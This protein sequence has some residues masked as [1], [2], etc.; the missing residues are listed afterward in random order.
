MEYTFTTR[1][2][3]D[4]G[5]LALLDRTIDREAAKTTTHN[6]S[7]CGL[8]T[9]T[10]IRHRTLLIVG[11][12][13]SPPLGTTGS[14]DAAFRELIRRVLR[15]LTG[16]ASGPIASS[17]YILEPNRVISLNLPKAVERIRNP[18]LPPPPVR[19]HKKRQAAQTFVE[20]NAPWHLDR[21][22]GPT[23]QLDGLYRFQS[24]ADGVTIYILDTG[25]QI[26]HPEFGG[27][28]SRLANTIDGTID[29]C[30]G[31]G[32]H[33]SSLAVGL[34]FGVAKSAIVKIVKVLNC[35]GVGDIASLVGGVMAVSDD[36]SANPAKPF[37]LSM[38]LVG[39]ESA[40]MTSAIEELRATYHVIVV[41]AA[42]NSN[43]DACG[44]NPVGIAGVFG[45]GSTGSTDARSYFSNF[46]PC[47]EAYAPGEGVLGAWLNG[48]YAYLSGTSMATPIVAG[49]F[50]QL[51]EQIGRTYPVAGAGNIS[52]S[53]IPIEQLAINALL[54]QTWHPASLG[55]GALVYG[56]FDATEAN[57]YGVL[58]PG[59]PSQPLTSEPPPKGPPPFSAPQLSQPN[60]HHANRANFL[61][62]PLGVMMLTLVIIMSLG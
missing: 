41:A 7:D 22:D 10:T 37:I 17:D 58:S 32:T 9:S 40:S 33:V 60:I 20:A 46:G 48:G 36:A 38:S 3:V 31:H 61:S 13:V 24:W 14:R 25:C 21:L 12:T 27:R 55:G 53:A 49:V 44:G 39:P 1:L 15:A 4:S 57:S 6:F 23:S 54:S 43:Q 50:A 30:N 56:S 45:V 16:V 35:N 42:G 59:A 19:I 52:S 47:V 34:N 8:V 29:D 5:V 11:C 62:N 2:N 26:S 51:I 18:R 28:A